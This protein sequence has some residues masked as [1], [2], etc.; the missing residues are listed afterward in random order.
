VWAQH[1][2]TRLLGTQAGVEVAQHEEEV[3]A[4]HLCD[5]VVEG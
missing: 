5:L 4:G 1:A 2:V 3:V